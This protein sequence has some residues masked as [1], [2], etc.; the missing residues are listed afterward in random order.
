[1]QC[2]MYVFCL[3][4]YTVCVCVSVKVKILRVQSV[5]VCARKGDYNEW[6]HSYSGT[7]NFHI[8]EYI[9]PISAVLLRGHLTLAPTGN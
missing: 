4:L 3:L 5:C 2:H 1:M 6:G 7:Y 8:S 9:I